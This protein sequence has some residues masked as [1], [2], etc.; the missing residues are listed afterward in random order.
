MSW[1]DMRNPVGRAALAVVIAALG[2]VALPTAQE[3]RPTFKVATW[4]IRAGS[5]IEGWVKPA[6]FE[7]G[8]GN[9]TDSNKPLNAWGAGFVQPFVTKHVAD[10]A[11][12]VAFGTQEGWGCA[13]S[14]NVARLLK[15]WKKWTWGRSGVTL[16]TR[17]GIKGD[18][19]EFQIEKAG[20]DGA[21]E[22][23]WLLGGYVC[24]VADC[25][26][27]A[28]IAT[29]HLTPVSDKAWPE[30]VQKVLTHLASRT[31]P[32]LWMGDLNL[33]KSDQWSPPVRC[34]AA[35]APMAEAYD[36]IV[37]AGYVDAWAATQNGPGWTGMTSR[38]APRGRTYCGE[39]SDGTPYKRIDYVFA[40][41][42]KPVATELFAFTGAGTP[43]PSDHLGLKATIEMPA[44][45]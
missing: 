22:H 19:D 11:D 14:E 20:V 21:R 32:Q 12:V 39:N 6:G 38:K 41:G 40:K 9:C 34:G 15:G 43:H 27:T 18:W 25:S 36:R 4:N 16:F 24:L 23:R 29:T 7:S 10:D 2:L 30:H 1:F 8:T 37:K 28:Y 31:E 42:L 26:R 17:Y 35:T 44:A 45:R 13:R 3:S 5:G 33:W